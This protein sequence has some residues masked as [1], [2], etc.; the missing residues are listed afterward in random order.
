MAPLC[1]LGTVIGPWAERSKITR[2][3][4]CLNLPVPWIT[5]FISSKEGR[6]QIAST[7]DMETEPHPQ[8]WDLLIALRDHYTGTQG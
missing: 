4:R 7:S 5:R 2:D 1:E 6:G 8:D 3:L